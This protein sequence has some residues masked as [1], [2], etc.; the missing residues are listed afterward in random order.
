MKKIILLVFV[1]IFQTVVAQ[2]VTIQ[3]LRCEYKSN[4]VGIDDRNPRL[5]WLINASER[6]ALQTAYQIQVANSLTELNSGKNLL[7]DSGETQSGQSTQITYT[8]KPL[9]SRQH[10][11][12]RVKVKTNKGNSVWSEPAFWEMGLLAVADWSAQWIESEMPEDISKPQPAQL[13]RKEFRSPEKIVSA[14][15]YITSHGLYEAFLNGKRVGDELFTPGWTSYNKR[16]QYQAYDVTNLIQNGQ[17]AVGVM[18]GEGWFR[19]ELGWGG[20]RN[21]YG[22]K[23]A[24]LFRL[25]IRYASGKTEIIRSDNTWKSSTGAILTSEIY[26][27]EVYDARLEKQGWHLPN[28]SDQNWSSVKT[29]NI[30][31]EKLVA[32]AGVPVR[33]IEEIQ[34]KKILITS[35]GDTVID[36][37][38]NMVGWV[39]FK[40]QGNAG[41]KITLLHTEILDKKGN[42]YTENL[43]NAAAKIEYTLKGIGEETYEP[44]FTFMGFRYVAVKNYPGKL[45]LSKFTGVVIHSDMEKTGEF[46]CSNPLLNQLQ[47]N[48]QWGQKSNF[49]DVPT[50]CPQRDERLGWTGD[51][52]VFAPTAA[53]NYNVA[54]F[55]S[56]WMKDVAAEQAK[57]GKI[58]FVIP[59]VLNQSAGAEACGWADAV[60]IIPYAM[61]LHFGDKKILEVQYP[62][63]KAWVD[64]M[65]REAGIKFIR[66]TGFHFGDWLYFNSSDPGA[67]AAYSDKDFLATAFFAHSTDILRKTAK[68]LGKTEEEKIYGELHQNIKKAFQQE[69]IT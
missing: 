36:F 24:L 22:N 16:L 9:I 32:V 2:K 13:F 4:P 42:F 48:I 14:K 38:Q 64:F 57:D 53:F 47:H 54:P 23:L 21:I 43:R 51:A 3:H 55:F 1:L 11:F 7:W 45:D 52:E 69:F 34:A 8:G 41:T 68:V 5:S 31:K 65:K 26:D 17:N 59:D 37:G 25:E 10:C 56:K 28:Y 60:T 18:L 27:G 35:E 12:W 67:E 50:D 20:N 19:G 6:G 39:K 66:N 63:M 40:V 62:S 58:P 46:E 15:V 33:R 29:T 30:S 49:L 44:H 61:Y